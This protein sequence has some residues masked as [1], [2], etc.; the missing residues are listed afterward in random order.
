[1]QRTTYW[2]REELAKSNVSQTYI[3]RKKIHRNLLC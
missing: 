3:Q 2:E 1:M